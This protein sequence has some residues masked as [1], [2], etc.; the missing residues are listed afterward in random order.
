MGR[1]PFLFSHR[2]ATP[3]GRLRRCQTRRVGEDWPL[4]RN[5]LKF[6]VGEILLD[7]DCVPDDYTE[8]SLAT[9][10]APQSESELFNCWQTRASE[11]LR[12]AS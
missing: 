12:H 3:V 7:A 10:M 4:R 8:I 6:I 11:S 2:S 5:R 1:L 9:R